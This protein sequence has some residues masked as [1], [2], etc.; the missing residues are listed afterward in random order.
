MGAL[1]GAVAIVTGAASGIGEATARRFAGDGARLILSDIQAER[2]AALAAELGGRFVPCDVTV[3]AE[4]EALVA[5]AVGA[6]GRLDC[7]INNAGQL[8][9]VGS[10]T[11]ISGAAWQATIAVLLT[12]VFFGMK[13]A[14]RVMRDQGEGVILSTASVGGLVALTPHVY[15][16]AKH[17]VVGL[18]RSVA[19]EMAG[20]G[21]RVN[22]VAPGN[23]PTRMTEL[24]YGDAEAMRRAAEARNPLKRLISADEIAG[25]FAYLAGPDGRNITGQVLIVDAGLT[26]CRLDA[27][28]YGKPPAFFDA[29]GSR[30]G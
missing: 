6:H 30:Q 13:H 9:A 27:A 1:Q 4:V 14:A 7:M 19:S 20:Y 18:T 17:G 15:A 28:Y 24:A 11:E 12:S 23:V 8:G 22:A 3:E 21:V 25:A 29:Q 5:A 16:A 2:G 26:E 10:I